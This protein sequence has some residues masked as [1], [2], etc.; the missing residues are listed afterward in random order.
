MS[1][2]TGAG[3]FRRRSAA[4]EGLAK[5]IALCAVPALIALS[6]AAVD[7]Q[8]IAGYSVESV[9][10]VD[11]FGGDNAVNTPQIVIDLS[12]ALRVNDNWQ[13]YVRPWL[14]MPRP[15]AP[16]L[17]QPEWDTELY[18]AGV[19]YERPGPIATRVDAGY[20]LSP[21]GLGLYDVRPGVNPTIVTHLGYVVPMPAFDPTAPRVSAI[22]ASYPLGAQL[23]VSTKRWD[24]RAAVIGSAPTRVYA[25]GAV[26]NPKATPVAVAGG[27]ITPIAGLRLG[28]A[29]AH[30]EYATRDEIASPAPSRGRSM[31]MVSGEGEYAFAGTAIA[32]EVVRTGFDTVGSTTA[33]AYEWFVQ[34]QQTLT[35]RWFAASRYEGTAAPPAVNGIVSGRPTDMHVVEATAGYRLAPELTLR[36]SYYARRS[37]GALTWT[38]Q[39]GASVVWSRRWW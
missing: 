27:G 6:A 33:V 7:A 2:R 10:A 28:A 15:A 5:R 4:S 39:A 38:N 1:D 37:Y 19:R 24:A 32:G 11:E 14:R 18:Q 3:A 12:A 35:P 31:T 29:V 30:G 17:P 34:A 9:V 8:D 36:G 25:V 22:A 13:V 20:I 26:T 21:I 23:T 16:G